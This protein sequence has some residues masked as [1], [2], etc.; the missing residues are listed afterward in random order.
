MRSTRRDFHGVWMA[1]L[2][3]L[4]ALVQSGCGESSPG[5]PAVAALASAFK[6]GSIVNAMTDGE[7]LAFSAMGG[8]GFGISRNSPQYLHF[9]VSFRLIFSQAGHF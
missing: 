9:R 5:G 2:V 6:D 1:M 3:G 8:K 4:M 7:K